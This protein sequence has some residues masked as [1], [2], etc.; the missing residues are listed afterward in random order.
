MW[1]ELACLQALK[2]TVEVRSDPTVVQLVI[3]C[4][5]GWWQFDQLP[6]GL[7]GHGCSD[8]F[9]RNSVARLIHQGGHLGPCFGK[10]SGNSQ[11]HIHHAA[12]LLTTGQSGN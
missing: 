10:A 3:R 11:L 4:H 12:E 1:D 8:L 5:V 6:Y 2:T 7:K 9:R